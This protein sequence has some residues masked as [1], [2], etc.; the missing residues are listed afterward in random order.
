MNILIDKFDIRNTLR[1]CGVVFNWFGW[2][3]ILL[4][5]L[6]DGVNAI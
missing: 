3:G 2:Y 5:W 1:W 4:C 6:F